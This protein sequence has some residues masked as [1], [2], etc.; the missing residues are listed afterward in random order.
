M[1]VIYNTR[2]LGDACIVTRDL[3][4]WKFT[5]GSKEAIVKRRTAGQWMSEARKHGW[6][7]SSK[8]NMEKLKELGYDPI[9]SSIPT[10]KIR[11]ELCK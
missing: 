10:S 7:V 11:K 6:I 5:S 3:D 2:K 4:K 1:I 8:A 9:P